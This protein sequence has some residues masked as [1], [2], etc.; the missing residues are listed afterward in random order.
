METTRL[1][2]GV[3][4]GKPIPQRWKLNAFGLILAV[5]DG[6]ED[7]T[8]GIPSFFISDD[9]ID[10]DQ[11]WDEGLAKV[12]KSL[13][14]GCH[15]G[16][17]N[18]VDK[19]GLEGNHAYA[20]LEAQTIP[21]GTRLVKVRNPW[22]QSEWEGD[23]SD[24]SK[25]WTDELRRLLKHEEADDGI[26]W[27]TYEDLL[28]NYPVLYRTR[29]FDASWTVAQS[30]TNITV[31]FLSS[32]IYENTF[33]FT[34][35][36]AATTVIVLS[37]LDKNYYKGLEGQ[38]DFKLSFRLHE[39][40]KDDYLHGSHN[41]DSSMRSVNVEVELGAGV[42]EVRLKITSE[43]HPGRPKIEDAV[44]LNWEHS[45]EKLLQICR[46]YDLAHAK[47]TAPELQNEDIKAVEPARELSPGKK[48]EDLKPEAK[49]D[50]LASS[51]VGV[52]RPESRTG[53]ST[54]ETNKH[55]KLDKPVGDGKS[56]IRE[57]RP[58]SKSEE[59]VV[60][61]T[62][63]DTTVIDTKLKAIERDQ[64]SDDVNSESTFENTHQGYK[65][66]TDTGLTAPEIIELGA[67]ING[68]DP[69]TTTNID[70][71]D[72]KSGDATAQLMHEQPAG[73][74]YTTST[75]KKEEDVESEVSLRTN[76]GHGDDSRDGD[77]KHAATKE[78]EE[79][80]AEP[81]NSVCTV[82]LR[83]YCKDAEACI[84]ICR[85]STTLLRNKQ[86]TSSKEKRLDVDD[87]AKS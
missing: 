33:R 4:S 56:D 62:I 24:R 73:A 71:E 6:L 83:V 87:P 29:I 84:E 14:W 26:F 52:S 42:Y 48:S 40:D 16:A 21:N 11:F 32:D 7:L 70:A 30:W 15:T 74:A 50:D 17:V 67:E 22:R 65:S 81:F 69:S 8:G 85:P 28:R 18:E 47:V 49:P 13:L 34:L 68:Y 46:S 86:F 35:S 53:G 54:S 43:R 77:K 51:E 12:N 57:A 37:Q 61:L 66:E 82:G 72:L 9:I 60:A 10:L 44:R 59:E 1:L 36:K 25:K 5:S 75:Q 55:V 3:R 78:N 27:I 79:H 2:M 39:V 19:R 64:S 23:W 31:P 41:R 38:Y 20:I 63:E 80:P 58:G 76:G 45:R